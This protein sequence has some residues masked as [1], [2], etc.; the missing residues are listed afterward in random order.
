MANSALDRADRLR[1]PAE[2][3]SLQLGGTRVTY[4]PDGDVRLRPRAMFPDTT[5]DVWARHPEYLDAS[6]HLVASIGALL[7]ERGD[8]ALLIDAGFGP[9][10][11]PADPTGPRGVIRGGA[12]L[13]NL[14]TLGR[15]PEEIEAIAFT[16]LHPDHT[17]WA[18]HP[19]PGGGRPPFAHADYLVS[20]P[21]W[22]RTGSPAGQDLAEEVAGMAHR[23]RP[24]VD[25]QEIFP[26]VRVR[27]SAGHTAGH[28]E[29]VIASGGQRLIA[30][31]DALHSPVQVEHP[32]WSSSFDHDPVGAAHHRRRLIGE[33][34]EPGT[35]A[36]GNHFADVVFGSVRPDG[37]GPAWHPL[38]V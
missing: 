1:R 8:R 7:V 6:G 14:A 15:R 28:A 33:L 10:T 20:E 24:V 26:G 5:H 2:I 25:G 35:I 29:Y 19:A 18:R 38:D 27:I 17:G 3:R 31:G 21:E 13:D 32:A 36:F 9:Q 37:G 22:S 12:L 30:F 16:H 23:V 4:V 11:L 34:A